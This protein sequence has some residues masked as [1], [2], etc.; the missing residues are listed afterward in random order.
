MREENLTIKGLWIGKELSP[1]EILCINSYLHHGHVFEL[2]V[3]DNV[4]NIP[5]G[6]KVKDATKIIPKTEI[7]T[8][9][10]REHKQS[11]A[12]FADM[13][14]FKL[15]FELGGW[16]SDM[17]AVCL[18]PYD[19][20]QEYVF[21]EEKQKRANNRVCNGIIKCPVSAP[22]MKACYDRVAE[23]RETIDSQI[24]TATG[25]ILLGEMVDKYQLG[26]FVVPP[27]YFSPI[28]YYEIDR[29]FTSFMPSPATYSIH[30]YNEVWSMR[31][32]S[33]Y[34]I[35]PRSC[36]LERMKKEHSVNNDH[37]RLVKELFFDLKKNG[38]KKGH[39]I[40]YNKLWFMQHAFTK[41]SKS[42]RILE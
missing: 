39:K 18:K 35:Y 8:F 25:P 41:L 22:I 14:R 5:G 12:A 33:K 13:F 2:F 9:S 4:Q 3:Y 28:G 34:G 29:L 15:L 19:M 6:V 36:L 37:S 32:I 31:D 26:E 20:E 16:W 24:W 27:E 21:I 42:K 10:N 1:N 11:F 23:M 17:D 7:F 40:I 30:L 38:L